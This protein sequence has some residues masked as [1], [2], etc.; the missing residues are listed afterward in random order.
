MSILGSIA[1]RDRLIRLHT[2]MELSGLSRSTIYRKISERE[3]PAPYKFGRSSLWKLSE[4]NN[5]IDNVSKSPL[6]IS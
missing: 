6:D 4:L 3:F 1:E 2:V 5:W